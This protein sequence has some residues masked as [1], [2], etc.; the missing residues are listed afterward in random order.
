MPQTLQP[1]P[2]RVFVL[3]VKARTTNPFVNW[4]YSE[5]VAIA[6][7]DTAIKGGRDVEEVLVFPFDV[8]DQRNTN[9]VRK[10]CEDAAAGQ[11]RPIR[12][13]TPAKTN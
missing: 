4:Y 7:F 10:R 2:G 11:V 13:W 8:P 9:D 6:L 3:A 5:E 1:V 12:R